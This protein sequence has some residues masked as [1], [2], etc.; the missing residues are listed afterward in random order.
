[1]LT[2]LMA[3]RSYLISGYRAKRLDGVNIAD[4]LVKDNAGYLC[5]M[6]AHS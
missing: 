5:D 1:M 4:V 3:W 2:C 6:H